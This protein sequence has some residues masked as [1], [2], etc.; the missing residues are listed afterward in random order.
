MKLQNCTAFVDTVDSKASLGHF[1]LLPAVWVY[2]PNVCRATGNQRQYHTFSSAA[3]SASSPMIF[4]SE[5]SQHSCCSN[6]LQ[7]NAAARAYEGISKALVV[8]KTGNT[9]GVNKAV[10]KSVNLK[11]RLQEIVVS[12]RVTACVT[13]SYTTLVGT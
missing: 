3:N 13:F 8:E 7:V 2:S 6:Q 12:V 9:G 1:L 5:L 4:L 10:G 11:R